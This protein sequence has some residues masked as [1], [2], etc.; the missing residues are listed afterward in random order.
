MTFHDC[1][2]ECAGNH[3]LVQ[4]YN[5]LNGCQLGTDSRSPLDRMID[6]ATGHEKEIQ[7]YQEEEYRQFITFVWDYVWLPLITKI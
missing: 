2:L 7:G 5:R 1:V 4:Q 3:S 6:E